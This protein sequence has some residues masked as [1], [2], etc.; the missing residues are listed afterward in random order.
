MCGEIVYETERKHHYPRSQG[1]KIG[2]AAIYQ[3]GIETGKIT[4]NWGRKYFCFIS[5]KCVDH[6][7][8]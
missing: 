1:G 7:D 6:T 3:D 4:Q 5:I 8:M 2:Y